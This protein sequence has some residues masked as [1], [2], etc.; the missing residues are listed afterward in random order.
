MAAT[1]R[2]SQETGCRPPTRSNGW[3]SNTRRNF[4]WMAGDISPTSSKNSVPPSAASNFPTVF[5][6]APVK[7]PFSW[8]NNSLSS[9]DSDSA[10][11]FIVTSGPADR[12]LCR[13]IALATNSLPTP[14]SPRTRT[15]ASAGAIWAM[16]AFSRRV[17]ALSPTI[18]P[19]SARVCRRLALARST[20]LSPSASFFFSS[21]RPSRS[22]ARSSRPARFARATA[23]WSATASVKS[24]SPP[25]SGLSGSSE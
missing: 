16:S 2:T 22:W 20:F 4:A 15:V 24:R 14:L 8:P 21:A 13:W 1:T 17:A 9:S 23:S 19:S 5:A 11:Q 18:A 7:A 12:R 10:A 3:P 6:V 25:S